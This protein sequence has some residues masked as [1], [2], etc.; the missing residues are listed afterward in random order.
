MSALS[1]KLARDGR[2]LLVNRIALQASGLP[3]DELLGT[4]FLDGEWWSYD[5]RVQQRARDAFCRAVAG[6][7]VSFAEKLRAVGPVM[8]I[9]ISLVPI[10]GPDAT[11]AY[12]VSEGHY[13]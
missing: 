11:L 10:S 2:I 3:L 12:I 9:M 4:S 1:A 13:I 5:P 6:T 8:T 7:T